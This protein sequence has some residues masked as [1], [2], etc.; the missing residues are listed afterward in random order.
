MILDRVEVS[1]FRNLTSVSLVPAQGLNIL[2]GKNGSGKT[3]FLESLHMLAMA[4]SF[5]TQKTSHLVH[6]GSECLVIFALL[7]DGIQHRL[8]LQRFSD[9]RMTIKVDGQILQSRSQLAQ[10]LPIQVITPDSIT[11][12]TGTPGDRRQYLDWIMFHVEPTFQT[13]WS[14]YQRFM[15]QRNA[16]IKDRNI[17]DISYWNKGLAEQ[18]E[19]LHKFRN[20]L[21][22]Q[23]QPHL[24]KYV[25]L[26]LPGITISLTYRKGWRNDLTLAEALRTSLETDLIQKYTTVGPHRGDLILR[27]NDQRIV[28]HFSRGQLKLVLCALKLAQLDYM[29]ERTGKTAVVLIDDLPAELD[30]EHRQLLLSLLHN[31]N[32]Q[33]FVTTTDRSH[34][35]FSS[36]D[37]VKVFHVE[38]GNIKE[39]V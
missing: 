32:N 21:V 34:L 39:V 3:S 28:D 30:Q 17:Q 20:T 4:R 6:H 12:I 15:L 8:G 11:L 36:W 24:D 37:D 14:Q 33:V 26:L 27:S 35:N 9:N 38:H 31:L 18:G 16:L 22:Q 2:E 7:R 13:V 23:L 19:T 10:L 5:R 25:E 1:A 29:K